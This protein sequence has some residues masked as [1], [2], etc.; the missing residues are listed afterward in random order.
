MVS[1]EQLLQADPL[2]WREQAQGWSDLG[3]ALDRHGDDLRARYAA[4]E[5]SWEGRTADG[6]H[7]HAAKLRTA[8][9]SS[10]ERI[11]AVGP[12]LIRHCEE[13]TTAQRRLRTLLLDVLDGPFLISAD[14]AVSFNLPL[15]VGL[16]VAPA[17]AAPLL[18]AQAEAI[19][20]EIGEVLTDAA[21][22]DARAVAALRAITPDVSGLGEAASRRSIPPVGTPPAQVKEW[23]DGMDEAEREAMLF[24]HPELLGALDGVPAV[25]RDRANRVVLAAAEAELLDERRHIL[26]GPLAGPLTDAARA[27]LAAIDTHMVGITTLKQRLTAADGRPPALLLG[28][29]TIG[30]GHAILAAGNPDLADNVLTFVPGTTSTLGNIG[31]NVEGVDRIVESA[32]QAA[33]YEST[34]AI[35]WLGYD[36]PQ[37]I[38]EPNPF[39]PGDARDPSYATNAGPALDRFQDG[40]RT[41]HEGPRSHN[42]VV[43]HSYGSTVV[44]ISARDHGLDV[45]EVVF[46]GSPGVGVEHAADLGVDPA[47]VWSSRAEN[48]PIRYA[49]DPAT[50]NPGPSVLRLPAPDP[51]DPHMIHGRDPMDPRFGGQIFDSDPGTPLFTARINTDDSMLGVNPLNPVDLDFSLDAHTEYLD[52][53]TESLANIGR[54]AVGHRTEVSR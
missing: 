25:Y 40:L 8:M 38:F 1:F 26:A 13:I 39:A 43:G 30:N 51:V 42:T 12:V 34:A 15:A 10:A 52:Q 29:D 9:Y 49:Y 17:V 46:I 31:G 14:G 44:G 33:P 47:H 22:S 3:S 37:A 48:D 45:D 36:A 5:Q 19:A 21:A 27:R 54:I 11:A 6:G 2:I 7:N 50:L 24:A 35:T 41:T 18:M 4:A 53:N 16:A 28:F 20:A 23:F 32:R